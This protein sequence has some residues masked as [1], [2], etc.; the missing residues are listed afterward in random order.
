MLA[1]ERFPKNPMISI[2]KIFVIYLLYKP[3]YCTDRIYITA[4]Y[5]TP[6]CELLPV[7]WARAGAARPSRGRGVRPQS[8]LG[9]SRDTPLTVSYLQTKLRNILMSPHCTG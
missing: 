9:Q 1:C 6:G 4:L 8:E 3:S 5:P 7:G 2:D